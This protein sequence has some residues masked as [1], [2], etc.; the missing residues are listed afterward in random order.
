MRKETEKERKNAHA[1]QVSEGHLCH[2]KAVLVCE[3]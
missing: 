2:P 3:T 1:L